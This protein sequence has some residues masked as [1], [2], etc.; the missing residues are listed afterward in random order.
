M[1]VVTNTSPLI[2]L[3]RIGQIQLLPGLFTSIIRPNAVTHEIREGL[4]FGYTDR[5]LD[6]TDWLKTVDD[7][8]EMILRKELGAGETS[9]IALAV[10]LK[11]DWILLD[12]LAARLVAEELGL[13]VMG[14]LGILMT[15]YAKG[16]LESAYESA[17]TLQIAG[18]RVS[19]AL[20]ETI[21]DKES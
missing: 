5:L 8:P 9:A 15:A 10:R 7:P 4:E 16:L 18:F 13:Q 17:K 6:D 3:D 19:N 14:T 12:D 11:A 1:I 20:L 21:K 2:A